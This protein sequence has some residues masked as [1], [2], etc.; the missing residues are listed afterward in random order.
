M[1]Q[2]G[3][4]TSQAPKPLTGARQGVLGVGMLG[5]QP[6]P[7]SGQPEGDRLQGGLA[8]SQAS[9]KLHLPHVT[10]CLGQENE[11]LGRQG[12]RAGAGVQSS[13]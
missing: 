7:D 11:A 6:H 4:K 10:L 8:K 2:F 12:S 5:P 1:G 9:G 13:H 3:D